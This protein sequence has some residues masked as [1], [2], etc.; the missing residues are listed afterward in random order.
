MEY[1]ISI[2][3]LIT[4]STW[5]DVC[6]VVVVELV[7]VVYVVDVVDVDVDV[8]VDVDVDVVTDCFDE[9]VCRFVIIIC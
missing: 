4:K 5:F 6:C 3:K 8:N 2:K 7:V 1:A 9:V